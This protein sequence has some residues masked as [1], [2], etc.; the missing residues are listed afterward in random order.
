MT[1]PNYD[2]ERDWCRED[3]PAGRK[4]SGLKAAELVLEAL[5]IVLDLLDAIF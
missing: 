5:D 3:A 4:G 1:A 2:P